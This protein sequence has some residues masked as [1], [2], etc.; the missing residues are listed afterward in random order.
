MTTI[1]SPQ[2]IL[3]IL[4]L[5][6]AAGC[7]SNSSSGPTSASYSGTVSKIFTDNCLYCHWPKSPIG[8]QLENP[9]DPT[10]GIIGR[11][12]SWTSARNTQLV[13]PGH[14]EQ[15]F[16]VDKIKDTDLNPDT[17]G[18]SM[19]L[20][21]PLVTASELQAIHDWIQ[22]GAL[23]DASFQANVAPIFGD[24]KSL[25]TKA[26]KCSYC[27]APG[28]PNP[29]DLTN[30]FDPARG[31]VNVPALVGGTRVIPGDPDNS[32]LYKKVSG[33]PLPAALKSPM[34]FQVPKLSATQISAIE[35][36]ITAGAN[37]D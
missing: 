22:G 20:D 27:H 31:V 14:P 32:V 35:A 13:V 16:L 1:R 30:P 34:P 19:P 7:G 2:I 25:G 3:S 4:G 23:N 12:T 21:N 29:P 15:S 36:W 18:A 33:A 28:S 26:G 9:F 24:G 10:T 6:A 5:V 11:A 37:N 17:E 8:Y